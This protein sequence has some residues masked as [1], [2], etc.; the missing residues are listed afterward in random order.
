MVKGTA[1]I[2]GRLP[3]LLQRS[4]AGLMAVVVLSLL[5]LM[6]AGSPEQISPAK[7][8]FAPVSVEQ[9]L[10]ASRPELS[11][12][13]FSVRPIFAIKRVPP[14]MPVVVDQ[15]EI[16][17]DEVVLDEV[18]EG[19]DGISLLG[20]FGS[21]EVAGVIIR[22]DNGERQRLPVGQSVGGWTVESL[23]PRGALFRAQTGQRASLE[24]AFSNNQ[25]SEASRAPDAVPLP[26]AVSANPPGSSSDGD[27]DKAGTPPARAT[28]ETM[29]GGASPQ[30]ADKK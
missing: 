10:L 27:T 4:V 12:P 24:M 14:V 11:S 26:T 28:F 5:Y 7:S 29:Y 18:V 1:A 15:Q 22:L 25:S 8:L 20:I 3:Q 23:Q 9:A 6:L 19:I 13:D 16:S 21:G 2:W 17:V 30:K